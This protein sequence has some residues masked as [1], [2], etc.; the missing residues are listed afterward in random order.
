MKKKDLFFQ[1]MEMLGLALSY[2][3]V[4]LK[5][6]YSN[7]IPSSEE[8]DLIS[9]FSRRI[10]LKCPI[11][12]SPMDRVTESTTAI[13]MAK[14]GGLGIIHRGLTPKSQ[15]DEVARVKF[16][17]NGLIEKP[18]TV[19]STNRVSEVLKMIEEKNYSFHS[20]PVLD[21][22]GQLVGIVSGND[23]DFCSNTNLTIAD[24]MSREVIT[25]P[26]GICL[27]EA[28]SIMC[29]HKVKVLPLLDQE[30]RLAGLYVFSDV[31][32]II[33]GGSPIYNLD[34]RGSLR[35]GAAIGTGPEAIARAELLVRK[36]VDVLVIDTAHSDTDTAINTL[37]E[38][39]V[40]YPEIDIVVGNISEADSAKRL[41]QAGADG[42]KV[43][44]GPGSICTTRIVAGIGCPQVTA[45][46]NCAMAVQDF[47]IPVCA[48][49]GIKYSGDI[50]IA[51]GAG[52]SSVMLGGLLAGTDE[53]PGKVIM[54]PNGPVKEYRGMGSLG[55]M[56]DSQEARQRY[57]QVEVKLDKLVPEGVEAVIP[58]RGKLADVIFQLVGGLKA[59][60]GY[61]GARTISELEDKADFYRLS[62][63]GLGESHP[64]GITLTKLPPNYKG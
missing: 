58:Y 44:Q 34:D 28:F 42:V 6:N 40:Q 64:H 52:A 1:N 27:T 9:K 7:V 48:D 29:Q 45:V 59:G 54:T 20:F 14:L 12:S 17:L 63:A 4:R 26:K 51:F 41:A 19:F 33:T 62:G 57:G 61:V 60:M 13:E 46:Y 35:V 30:S 21:E 16:Y 15:S 23:F 25:A 24:I 38:L 49:G 39:K 11:V 3:D 55:A 56:Q 50:V 47:N 36:K 31:K 2:D 22:N 18:I 32:R 5:T 37:T 53:S 10:Q 43:G 8:I